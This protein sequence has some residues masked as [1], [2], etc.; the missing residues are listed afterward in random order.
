[1]VPYALHTYPGNMPVPRWSIFINIGLARGLVLWWLW[2][3]HF[4]KFWCC[5][6]MNK[7]DMN[8]RLLSSYV[9]WATHGPPISSLLSFQSIRRLDMLWFDRRRL[10][11]TPDVDVGAPSTSCSTKTSTAPSMHRSYWRITATYTI[12]YRLV[13]MVVDVGINILQAVRLNGIQRR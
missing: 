9:T 12:W 10:Y 1:M 6:A 5:I 3:Q 11:D 7:N 13:Q 8:L 4:C 2:H